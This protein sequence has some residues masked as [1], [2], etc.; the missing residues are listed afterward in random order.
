MK[1]KNFL[2]ALAIVAIVGSVFASTFYTS[3]SSLSHVSALYQT[4]VT[5]QVKHNGVWEPIVYQ[6]HNLV[7]YSGLNWTLDKL[8]TTSGGVATVMAVANGTNAEQ[9][10]MLTINT[11][12]NE[13]APITSCGLAPA[14]ISGA[15]LSTTAAVTTNPRNYSL[16]YTWVSTCAINV[17]DTALYNSSTMS[18]F[19]TTTIMFAGKNFGSAVGLTSGDQLNVTWYVWATST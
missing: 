4:A 18:G 3:S 2:V 6:G 8:F 13:N 12:A 10:T 17:N 1:N 5:T 16:T 7:V 11:T 19:G 9:N 15:N 14:T